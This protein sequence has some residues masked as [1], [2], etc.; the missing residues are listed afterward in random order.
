M[1]LL[2]IWKG[3]FQLNR[4]RTTISLLFVGIVLPLGTLTYL[5]Y[6]KMADYQQFR[7]QSFFHILNGTTA[8]SFINRCA[9]TMV[10]S[11]KWLGASIEMTDSTYQLMQSN[12]FILTQLMA[13]YGMVFGLIVILAFMMLISHM[14]HITWKQKNQLGFMI[15]S[16]C[17]LVFIVMIM[18]GIFINLG[19]FPCTTIHIPFLTYGGSVTIFYDILLGLLLSVYRYQNVVSDKSFRPKWKISLKVEKAMKE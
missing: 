7:I 8:L 1:L 12:G 17:G 19:L 4:V 3:W 15:G 2:A 9:N 5:Y 13:S 14:F 11:S 10:T 16:G 6:F 18:E